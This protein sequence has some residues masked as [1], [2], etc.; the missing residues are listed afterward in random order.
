M[1][2]IAK[3]HES[4][5][6]P[7]VHRAA[8]RFGTVWLWVL[9]LLL[10]YIITSRHGRQPPDAYAKY[11]LLALPGLGALALA[12]MIEWYRSMRR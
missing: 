2:S 6:L 12:W 4:P 9:G 3:N 1:F 7:S 10:L 8:L 11:V 5:L